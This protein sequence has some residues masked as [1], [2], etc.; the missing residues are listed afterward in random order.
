MTMAL[1]SPNRLKALVAV[2]NAPVHAILQ[3]DFSKY[4]QG[5][6]EVE[7]AK[8]SKQLEADEILKLYE[9]VCLY[10][11]A[12]FSVQY[13][14]NV[15]YGNWGRRHCLYGNF[16][17]RI[18]FENQ[19]QIISVCGSLSIY[20]PRTLHIWGVSHSKTLNK[21]GMKVPRCLYAE[22]GVAT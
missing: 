8:V 12:C 15:N 17:S 14:T 16:Y 4:V 10:K 3:S 20:S 1:K 11:T 9:K 6:Q 21:H 19:G 7:R 13:R 5:L 2:D 18:L 22:R